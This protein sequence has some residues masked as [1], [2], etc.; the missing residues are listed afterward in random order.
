MR[1]KIFVLEE[2]P[3][4]MIDF[5]LEEDYKCFIWVT[6]DLPTYIHT[7]HGGKNHSGLVLWVTRAR[8]RALP[9]C[10]DGVDEKT[11]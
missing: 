8:A 7:T 6:H 1:R 10:H 9:F 5:M 3:W 11:F 2:Q 4:R